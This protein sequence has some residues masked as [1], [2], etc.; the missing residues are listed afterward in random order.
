VRD[1]SDGCGA[2][3]DM[4]VVASAFEGKPLLDRHRMVNEALG[5]N[6]AKIH[7]VTMK[8][9]TPMQWETKKV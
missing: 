4:I 1:F 8:T 6:M 3:F 7:A 9:W 2:K 5:D